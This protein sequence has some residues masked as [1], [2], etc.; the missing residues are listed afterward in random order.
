[1]AKPHN[2]SSQLRP[3]TQDIYDALASALVDKGYPP[4]VR[5]LATMVGMTSPSSVK[6]HLDALEE[7]GFIRRCPGQPRAIEIIK[8][9][10]GNRLG[11][12]PQISSDSDRS[13]PDNDFSAFTQPGSTDIDRQ[14]QN[15][16]CVPLVGHIA[17]GSPILAEQHVEDTFILP[18]QITGR[19]EVFML[20]VQGDSMVDAAICDGDYVI[21]RRQPT[22]EPGEIVAALLD[23]EATVK[24][25]SYS[26]GHMW[27][28][29][30]NPHYSPILGDQAQILG[31]IVAV[32]RTI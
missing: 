32:L 22:A 12:A 14:E 16:T 29:P 24:T 30:H 10:D 5:E 6:H 18:Y 7:K 11:D 17:A 28:L 8:D 9:R 25:L 4:S 19:G 1:M 15:V 3:R 2:V 26:G 27:L 13:E 23:D 21:V 20:R 31:K